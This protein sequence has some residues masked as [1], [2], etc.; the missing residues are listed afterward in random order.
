[1][2]YPYL[3]SRSIAI[4]YICDCVGVSLPYAQHPKGNRVKINSNL[5]PKPCLLSKYEL[6]RLH[7]N[8]TK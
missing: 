7:H 3:V 8:R 5:N 2:N 6:P 4:L 1:M